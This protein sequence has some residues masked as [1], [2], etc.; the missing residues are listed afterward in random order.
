MLPTGF[1]PG[2]EDT[3]SN[4]QHYGHRNEH[5]DAFDRYFPNRGDGCIYLGR[6]APGIY[7]LSP[8]DTYNIDV[9]FVDVII[10]VCNRDAIAAGPEF[11]DCVASGTA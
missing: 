3:E 4:G 1:I 6:D 8:G 10:D 9:H 2:Q 11:W 7:N 5:G